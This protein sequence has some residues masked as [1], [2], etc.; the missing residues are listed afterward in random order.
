M[1]CLER[2]EEGL[3]EKVGGG[4]RRARRETVCLPYGLYRMRSFCTCLV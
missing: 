4:D 3:K 1:T 2:G